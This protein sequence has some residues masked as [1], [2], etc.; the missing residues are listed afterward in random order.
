[1]ACHLLYISTDKQPLAHK[2][3]DLMTTKRTT[4]LARLCNETLARLTEAVRLVKEVRDGDRSRRTGAEESN[5]AMKGLR[6]RP[7]LFVFP[8]E[9]LPALVGP[10]PRSAGAGQ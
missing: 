8:E 10:C 3:T 2:E 1:M 4:T 9:S 6:C 7:A 5:E